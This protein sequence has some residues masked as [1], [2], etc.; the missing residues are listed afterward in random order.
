[1]NATNPPSSEALGYWRAFDTEAQQLA[2]ALRAGRLTALVGAS[3]LERT[4][5]LASGVLPLLRRRVDDYP[6]RPEARR[7]GASV[8]DRRRAARVS[9]Q[10]E[11]VFTFDQWRNSRLASLNRL[12]D[13][14]QA[15]A[16]GQTARIDPATTR[17]T[18]LWTLGHQYGGAR[19]LFV[20]DHFE[21]L[22]ESPKEAANAQQFVQG[23]V[24]VLQEPGLDANFL[25]VL[26]ER[27]W[28]RLKKLG[29]RIPGF[30]E[31]RVFELQARSARQALEPVR[32]AGAE[33][34]AEM[35][36][37]PG[38][39]DFDASLRAKLSEVATL[40]RP[41]HA[42][43]GDF[44]AS[45]DAV[46]SEVRR[47][48][49]RMVTAS[50]PEAPSSTAEEDSTIAESF[51]AFRKADAVQAAEAQR[52]AQ[53]QGAA[54]AE[55]A[56]EVEATR[57]ADAEAERTAQEAAAAEDK[58]IAEELRR[59]EADRA[60]E[61]QRVAQARRVAEA[62]AAREV[63]A[64]RAAD[65]QAKRI[66]E[67]AAA[68]EARRIAEAQRVAQARRA[69]EAEAEAEAARAAEAQRIA[70]AE[71]KRIAE[72]AAA[73]EAARM[74]EE[75]RRVEAERAAEAARRAEDRR[76][77]DVEAKRV[78]EAAAA[79]EAR[80]V[81]P[82]ELA[83]NAAPNA[84]PSIAAARPGTPV[85]SAIK[86]GGAT[87][88]AVLVAA[89][90]W[91]SPRQRPDAPNAASPE[92]STSVSST[93]PPTTAPIASAPGT[94]LEVSS[95]P[96]Q[97][98]A[99]TQTQTDAPS[100]TAQT[101]S[102]P[103]VA[104]SGAQPETT[105]TGASATAQ[106]ASAPP[107]A[108]SG[109]PPVTTEPGP[110]T[111]WMNAGGSDARIASELARAIG[112]GAASA[113]AVTAA[114][115]VDAVE[116]LRAPRSLAIARY[117]ALRAARRSASAPPLR[118]LAPLYAEEVVF[119]VRADSRLKFIHDLR[120]R[121]VNIGSARE[122]SSQT[123]RAI[124]R[125]MFGTAMVEPS[126]LGKDEALAELIGFRSIDAMVLVDP[127]PSAWLAS[128]HPN[129]ARGLR[130]LRLDRKQPEDRKVLQEFQTSVLRG[131]PG[132][133]KG[134][135]IPTL[136]TMS[137]LVVSGKDDADAKQLTDMVSALCRELPRLRADG[138]P[139]W[140]ELQP[141]ANQDTGWPVFAAGK[142]AL[143]N[144]A[145]NRPAPARAPAPAPTAR[146]APKSHSKH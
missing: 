93:Q 59:V 14:S 105:E 133:K 142:S 53:D 86:W 138:H 121:R 27:A 3:G 8:R 5:M 120:G 47:S 48:A 115:E 88:A 10:A 79:D 114:T 89:L 128:L 31:M 134:E 84:S 66:A 98:Q 26:D 11:V 34:Q 77:A 124:Y 65:A 12:L 36:T 109:A 85:R 64:R 130:L 33:R 40:A 99:Q 108:V 22:L 94:A 97:T 29:E 74:A 35:D 19:I 78:A 144:C 45:V 67:E 90:L 42:G 51:E 131:G 132:L 80:R 15:I 92:A 30:D 68:A 1:V 32:A 52:F 38:A 18:R 24:R 141:W 104:A 63:E 87:L 136:A 2:D 69:A 71:A 110:F 44:R 91:P 21:Q 146:R 43:P 23:W 73:A 140:R 103:P 123:V 119:I 111:V 28:P 17:P 81:E 112:G 139:K 41:G 82:V 9:N 107:L 135:S 117:D 106:T 54:E 143:K 20:F 62:E 46:L 56:R 25:V 127:Q 118:V 76:A 145:S 137:Y 13:E 49:R 113:R 100:A 122:G 37:E 16:G 101:A 75:L 116:S 39:V 126:Q 50:L 4:V 83:A 125:Q 55:A 95:A 58:R 102:A 70:D 60:A 7:M 129:T 72:V 96:I 61:A 6:P 57:A